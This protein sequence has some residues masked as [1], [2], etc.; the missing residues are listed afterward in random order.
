L[1][2]DPFHLLARRMDDPEREK[3]PLGP[4]LLVAAVVVGAV[5]YLLFSERSVDRAAQT[6]ADFRQLAETYQR[7]LTLKDSAPLSPSIF[8]FT[9]PLEHYRWQGFT[10]EGSELRDPWQTAIR[11]DRLPAGIDLVSAGPD[12]T[13]DTPDDIRQFLPNP[14]KDGM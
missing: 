12:R 6:R 2:F 8:M 13:F 10:V 11:I 9:T 7:A 3:A 4:K 1:A 14:P 5:L